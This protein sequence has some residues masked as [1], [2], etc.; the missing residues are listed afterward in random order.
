M[1][2]QVGRVSKVGVW[3]SCI[4]VLAIGR[5]QK[6]LIVHMVI[7][8]AEARWC[9]A[10]VKVQSGSLRLLKMK[11]PNVVLFLEDSWNAT[12]IKIECN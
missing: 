11:V 2:K 1:G 10:S 5:A 6:L 4:W 12:E 7:A 9:Q 3:L 8:V